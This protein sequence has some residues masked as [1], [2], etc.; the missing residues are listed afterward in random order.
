MVWNSYVLRFELH[1]GKSLVSRFETLRKNFLNGLNVAILGK[2]LWA[3]GVNAKQA[4][5]LSPVSL[6]SSNA[7]SRFFCHTVII[8]VVVDIVVVAVVLCCNVVNFL[9]LLHKSLFSSSSEIKFRLEVAA[10]IQW[11]IS[12]HSRPDISSKPVMPAMPVMQCQLPAARPRFV[13]SAKS[14]KVT[15]SHPIQALPA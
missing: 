9:L 14:W 12:W 1:S 11:R 6:I 2:V 7:I 8:V 13:A 15:W 5:S 3:V 4:T 10:D